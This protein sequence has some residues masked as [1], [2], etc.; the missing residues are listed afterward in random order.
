MEH[1]V[2]CFLP[3]VAWNARFDYNVV[4]S[5]KTS[6]QNKVSWSHSISCLILSD[7]TMRSVELDLLIQ[8]WIIPVFSFIV[9]HHSHW[10]FRWVGGEDNAQTECYI[11]ILPI[12]LTATTFNGARKLKLYVDLMNCQ[13]FIWNSLVVSSTLNTVLSVLFIIL[14]GQ[15]G[16]SAL[17]DIESCETYFP[18]DPP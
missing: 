16:L 12:M 4:P 14:M 1:F 10:V 2:G 9:P 8:V 3:S 18:Y 6:L 17:E 11:D 13:T 7:V 15:I 5:W